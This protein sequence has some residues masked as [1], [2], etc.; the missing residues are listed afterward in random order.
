MSDSLQLYDSR[1]ESAPDVK[2]LGRLL[3][4]DFIRAQA[5]L[6]PLLF[7]GGLSQKVKMAV[8]ARPGTLVR[9]NNNKT[10][11]VADSG[12]GI[13]ATGVVIAMD[14]GQNATVAPLAFVDV[15]SLGGSGG[16]DQQSLWLGNSGTATRDMPGSGSV[17]LVGY[18]WFFDARQGTRRCLF[19]PGIGSIAAG[20][21]QPH[22]PGTGLT[23][24][25]YDGSAAETW[26]VNASYI[27][28]L[29]ESFLSSHVFTSLTWGTS[30]G[31][32]RFRMRWD[33]T[34]YAEIRE[35]WNGVAWV[36]IGRWDLSPDGPIITTG[37]EFS[38]A[39]E[40][41]PYFPGIPALM[42]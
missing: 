24:S 26:V 18:E 16:R 9:V 32:G 22:T 6:N 12:A 34:D 21:L 15:P 31:S 14:A 35:I 38:S 37:F 4:A 2:T 23:G 27:E 29:F 1:L 19:F 7:A 17:Q 13:A 36:E 25:A 11:T 33:E 42:W 5:V 30:G 39:L 3:N 8:A 20:A 40:R 10:A 28:T 41:I